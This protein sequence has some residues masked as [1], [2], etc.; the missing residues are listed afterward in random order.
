MILIQN[1]LPQQIL[2]KRTRSLD[3]IFLSPKTAYNT[4]PNGLHKNFSCKF[5]R[6]AKNDLAHKILRRLHSSPVI[7]SA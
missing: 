3:L 5:I 4:K 7:K 1:E 6:A 2:G